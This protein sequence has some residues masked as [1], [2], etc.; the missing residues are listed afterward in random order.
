MPERNESSR[1]KEGEA[2][3]RHWINNVF[4]VQGQNPGT[5]RIGGAVVEITE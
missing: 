5:W 4:R 2:I 3:E 1:D